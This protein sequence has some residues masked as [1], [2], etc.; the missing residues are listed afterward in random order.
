MRA[1]AAAD[2]GDNAMTQRSK[3]QYENPL[4][5]DTGDVLIN[6][7]GL[8]DDIGRLVALRI[9]NRELSRDTVQNVLETFGVDYPNWRRLLPDDVLARLAEDELAADEERRWEARQ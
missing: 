5:I 4:T 3:W 9:S 1:C 2:K 6:A 7:M 8:Y